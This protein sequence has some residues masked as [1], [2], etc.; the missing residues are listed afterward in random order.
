MSP[1]ACGLLGALGSFPSSL[2]LGRSI[3]GRLSLAGDDAIDA[4]RSLLLLGL[5]S[6]TELLAHDTG[7]EAAHRVLLPASR[8]HNGRNRNALRPAQHADDFGLFGICPWFGLGRFPDVFIL[9]GLAEPAPPS[10]PC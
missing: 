9:A 10:F 8:L 6:E 3:A 1:A 2:R 5:E 7:K 4:V